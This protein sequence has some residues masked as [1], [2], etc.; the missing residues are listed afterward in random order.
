MTTTLPRYQ[1]TAKPCVMP[2]IAIGLRTYRYGPSRTKIEAVEVG[3]GVPQPLVE[4]KIAEPMPKL[5]PM[6]NKPVASVVCQGWE[7]VEIPKAA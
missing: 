3:R 4:M 6:K 7:N 5:D 1:P 2:A